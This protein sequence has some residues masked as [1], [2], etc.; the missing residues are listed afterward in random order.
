MSRTLRISLSLAA[1]LLVLILLVW[2]TIAR[3]PGLDNLL[4]AALFGLLIA[5]TTTFGV[6]LAGG[7]ISLL[8]TT[9]VAA[10]LVLGPLWTA[11]A[12]FAGA[13]MH[14][15]IRYRWAK[16]LEERLEP[17]LL[18]AL[19]L[20]ATNGSVQVASILAGSLT[21]HWAGSTTPLT[22]LSRA[23][24]PA[25]LLLSLTY[26]GT[27]LLLIASV[28]AVRGR[29]PLKLYLHSL[30][31]VLIY[32][33]L[34]MIFSPLLALVYTQ[35][36]LV[37]FAILAV[38]LIVVSLGMRGLGLAQRRLE[39]RVQELDSLQA[40]GQALSA[41]LNLDTILATIHTEVASL[42]P[43]RNF[44][45]ALYEQDTDMVSFPLAW[46]KGQRVDWESRQ[47]GNGLTEYILR[48][49]APLLIRED[50]GA[51]LDALG[52]DKI[53]PPATS[54]LGVPILAGDDALGV[55]TVQSYAGHLAYDSSHQAVLVTI[56]GQATVAI[57]NARIYTLTDET[58]TRRLQELDSILQTT[59]DGLLLLD[60]DYRILAANPTLAG[61]LG[62]AQQDLE[63]YTLLEPRLDGQPSLASLVGY[64]SEGL[65]AECQILAEGERAFT[66]QGIVVAGP[67]ERPVERTLTPVRDQEG[68]TTG[69]L[70]V[71]RDLAEEHALA[72]L[73]EEMTR[74][75]LHDL[76]SPLTVV[77]SSL[78]FLEAEVPVGGPGSAGEIVSV[79]QRSGEHVLRLV[80][81]LLDIS[82]LE[83]GQMVIERTPMAI[84]P[85]LEEVANRVSPLA[86][87]ARIDLQTSIER[88]LPLL[89]GSQILLDRVVNNL[90]DN[91]IKFTP[92]GGRVHLWAQQEPEG[93]SAAVL[94]G[95]T[96]TG[97][98]IPL[99]DQSRLFM[100]YQRVRDVR[101]RRQGLG[102]GL[103]F[104]KL[105]VEAH[106]GE[107]WVTSEMGQGSTFAMRL[108]AAKFDD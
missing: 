36:G 99:E 101:G 24:L 83:S 48:T 69:W 63:G 42:M 13:A 30:P 56:A 50:Y 12:A 106:G 41:S 17:G 28:F 97:P 68:E 71:F 40:V 77:I 5:F 102:L 45:V 21:F 104:C 82:R 33:G 57:Q 65:D 66:R 88:G 58:L 76:R 20:V 19:S 39:R 74:M 27:N 10:Y 43:A 103:A 78:Q 84:R 53:G 54:W 81:G 9:T 70:L 29:E 89:E 92:D 34:P 72:K 108:P 62:L 51:T 6:P 25:L 55:I 85:L 18:P 79:A 91:A 73:R 46:E 100:K 75:L 105:A 23:G 59:H 31:N 98:G 93:D 26:L 22:E 87:R 2:A 11:G 7:R 94:V 37:L 60:P 4:P 16:A 38:A 35:L 90:L 52:I 44:Y 15:A 8:P 86:D 47:T 95:V 67:P 80:D 49:R 1:G 107:I 96:D 61:Y 3:P 32:E 64:T 14:V